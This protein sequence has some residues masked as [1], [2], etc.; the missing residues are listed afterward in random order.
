[1][2]DKQTY[3]FLKELNKCP[4][5]ADKA[6][7]AK[8]NTL[9]LLLSEHLIETEVGVTDEDGG[10]YIK[11]FKVSGS[12]KAYIEQKQTE[13]FRFWFP[14]IVS[15]ALTIISYLGAFREEIAWLIRLITKE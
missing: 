10:I 9:E 13:R 3:K 4:L 11:S 6:D 14:I 1:M 15:F 12:G 7:D 5:E 8:R 2:I